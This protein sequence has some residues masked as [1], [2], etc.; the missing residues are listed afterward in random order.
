MNFAP[1]VEWRISAWL[2]RR[3]LHVSAVTVPVDRQEFV[4]RLNPVHEVRVPETPT[5]ASN[6]GWRSTDNRADHAGISRSGPPNVQPRG[7]LFDC[8]S[9][10]R[11][12]V[13]V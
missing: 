7:A 6:V 9:G 5:I 1:L 13:C 10:I 3:N 2:A 11:L 8:S 12:H 4:V